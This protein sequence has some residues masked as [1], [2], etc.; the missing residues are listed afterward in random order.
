[1]D[2]TELDGI[3]LR[4]RRV[5]VGSGVALH[6]VEAGTDGPLVL[7]LHGFPDFWWGWRM[8]IAPLVRAGFRVLVPDQ[9]GYATSD[10]PRGVGAYGLRVLVEDMVQLLRAC[11]VERAHVVGHDWGG[12]VA[13]GL[14]MANP[15]LVDRLVILNS[16]HPV[17]LLA[18]LRTPRQL[19]KSWYMFVFQLPRLPERAMRR[20]GFAKLLESLRGETRPGVFGDED[21]R[22]YVDAWS[23]PRALEGMIAWYRAMF[24]PSARVPWKRIER[25]VLVLWGDG[26]VHLGR[27]LAEPPPTLVP[28]ARVVHL[29][30][31]SHWVQIDEAARVNDELVAFLRAGE[32]SP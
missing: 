20:R 23:Q 30:G 24:R 26:D 16:P 25:P 10:K 8:Q 28:D 32:R 22:A 21:A 15:E 9:R 19:A 5:E 18:A 29:P 27:E 7:L 6:V 11:G 3:A 13:W 2:R 14:A 4:H 1:M 12:G 17:R 31:A